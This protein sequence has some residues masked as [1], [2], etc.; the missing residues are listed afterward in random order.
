MQLHEKYRPRT[1]ADVV[2]QDKAVGTINRLKMRGLSGRAYWITGN[3]GTGKTT[4]AYIMASDQAD[5]FHTREIVGRQVTP[6]ILN[7]LKR[8]WS[9]YPLTGNGYALIVNEAHGLTK[10]VI[11]IFLDVLENLP[12][13]VIVIFTTTRDGNDLFEEQL[14]SGPFASRCINI[15]LTTRGLCD[16][17]AARAKQIAESEGLDGQPI[18]AYVKLLKN[19]RNNMRTA[20]QEIES[21]KMQE[22]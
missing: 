21:G 6:S 7:D 10:P 16:V 12:S 9:Y 5:K 19:S 8:T 11:E 3:S 13:H 18:E 2:G 17:F 1:L 4:L 15:G 14:D 22:V 20:L